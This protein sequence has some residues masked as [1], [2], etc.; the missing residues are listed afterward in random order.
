MTERFRIVWTDTAVH[1]LLAIVDDI[2]LR[3]GVEAAT[4]VHE[5]VMGA[6]EELDTMPRRYRAVPELHAEG[7]DAPASCSSGRI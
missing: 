1:D 7:I 5:R 2:T 4:D 6:A 3:M